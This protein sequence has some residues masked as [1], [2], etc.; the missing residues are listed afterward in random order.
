MVAL[1]SSFTAP[2]GFKTSNLVD[3]TMQ[4]LNSPTETTHCLSDLN[5]ALSRIVDDKEVRAMGR[6]FGQETPHHVVFEKAF[7]F[8]E[9][10]SSI[11]T[12]M[13]HPVP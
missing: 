2:T 13:D 10:S 7:D 11:V 8:D 9:F 4:L 6:H 1:N 3:F 12:S 5:R